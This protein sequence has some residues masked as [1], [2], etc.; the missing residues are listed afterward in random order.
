MK[1]IALTFGQATL[2]STQFRLAQFIDS[3]AEE[4]V[5]LEIFPA[6]EPHN[7]PPLSNYDLVIVQK[8]L[9]RLSLVK[10]VR[11]EAKRLI[12]D[13]DDA[14]WE[15]HDKK[16]F[17]LTRLRTHSR[18]TAIVKAADLCTVPN[19][20]LSN[21]LTPIAKKVVIIPMALDAKT[22]HPAQPRPSGPLRIGWNGAPQNLIYLKTLEPVLRKI[23]ATNP[24]IE[25]IIFCGQ[26]PQWEQSLD[27][28]YKE[29]G[30]GLEGDILRLFDIG[31]LPLPTNSFAEGKSPIK[32]LQYAAS[33]IPCVASPVG[34][35]CEI[36]QHNLTG[37]LAT[38]LDDW[39]KSLQTIIHQDELRNKMGAQALEMFLKDHEKKQV[40]KK[41]M[42]CWGE[43]LSNL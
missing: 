20:H 21:Y 29:F 9:L 30:P 28:T 41:L 26:K 43:L 6:S 35:T 22:W 15:P 12:F 17:I 16:H 2:A 8:K 18:L 4:G 10:R 1:V 5:F 36:V 24:T 23:K 14:I 33:G 11:K 37:L 38:S 32:G 27:Y 34:A 40:Q 39:E 42:L 3:L 19:Q 25:I 7:W 31:L 13:T